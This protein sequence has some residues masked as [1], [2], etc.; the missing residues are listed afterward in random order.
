MAKK[1]LLNNLLGRFGINMERPITRI[2][3]RKTFNIKSFIHK[4]TSEKEIS[5]D[6][7]LTSYIP[8]L[9]YDIIKQHKLDYIK[10]ANKYK[11]K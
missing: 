10:V 5:E 1:S 3:D 8:K 6:R 2:L 4:V 9:D 7:I 11:D